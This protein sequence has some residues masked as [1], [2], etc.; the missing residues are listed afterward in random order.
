MT[1][2]SLF[3]DSCKGQNKNKYIAAALLHVVWSSSINVIDQKFLEAGHT[4]MEVDSIHS[5]IKQVKRKVQVHHPDQ[6]PMLG[7]MARP[8]Q[9][10]HVKKLRFGE[11]FDLKKLAAEILHETQRDVAGEKV[12]LTKLKH[13]R[14]EKSSPLTIKT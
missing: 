13:Y 9:P 6:W 7:S 2:V 5:T 1:D 10:A 4:Q 11:F 14:Y 8:K 12:H 3:S